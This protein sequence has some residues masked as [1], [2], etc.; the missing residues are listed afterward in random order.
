MLAIASQSQSCVLYYFSGRELHFSHRS[1]SSADRHCRVALPVAR[2]GPPHD[3]WPTRIT[4]HTRPGPQGGPLGTRFFILFFVKDRPKGPPTANRHQPPTTNRQRRP[5]ANRQPLPPCRTCSFQEDPDNFKPNEIAD[6]LWAFSMLGVHNP[7]L[8]AMLATHIDDSLQDNDFV[9]S[10]TWQNAVSL[11]WGLV[12]CGASG[13]STTAHL[14]ALAIDEDDPEPGHNPAKCL[15]HQ[16]CG[17]SVTWGGGIHLALHTEAGV[18]ALG[19]VF[20]VGYKDAFAAMSHAMVVSCISV[21]LPSGMLVPPPPKTSPP[22]PRNQPA[23]LHVCLSTIQS[24][25]ID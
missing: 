8:V 22:P 24:S 9:S 10:L 6:L 12:A 18:E 16:V 15:L 7:S 20:H 5:T 1:P 3:G 11:A 4:T 19:T 13:D 23:A 21:C 2:R 14:L 25:H 17:E